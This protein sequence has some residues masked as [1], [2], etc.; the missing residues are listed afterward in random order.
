MQE[1]Q[2]Q[3]LGGED[4]LEV[5][6]ATHSS[7]LAWRISMDKGAWWATVHGVA[8]SNTSDC[9]RTSTY[10]VAISDCLS[11]ICIEVSSMSFPG[12]ITPF[13]L[14]LNSVPLILHMSF[15]CCLG[16]GEP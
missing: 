9:I 11:V 7:T 15:V 10:S 8:E 1:T 12:F 16:S 3:S 5:E 14:A 13:F 2:V 6:M 4:P